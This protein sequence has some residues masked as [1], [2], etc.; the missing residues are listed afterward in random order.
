MAWFQRRWQSGVSLRRSLYVLILLCWALPLAVILF[1]SGR[2]SSAT[3][4]TRVEDTIQ[5]SVHWAMTG[6]EEKLLQAMTDSRSATYD[7]TLR[8][9]Y[10]SYQV[11]GDLLSLYDTTTHYLNGKYGY[12]SA[13]DAVYVLYPQAG[14][15]VFYS[16]G[17][18]LQDKGRALQEFKLIVQQPALSLSGEF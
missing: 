2:I 7:H 9:L 4:R 16:F 3:V 10:E 14:D 18:S 13:F 15:M 11:E 17:G 5:N 1:T 12:N 6:M 8:T